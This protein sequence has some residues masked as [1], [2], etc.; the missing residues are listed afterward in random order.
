MGAGRVACGADGGGMSAMCCEFC[1]RL[2]DTDFDPDSLYVRDHDGECVCRSCRN[3]RDLRTEFDGDNRQPPANLDAM[4][5]A[6]IAAD[7]RHGCPDC[8]WDVDGCSPCEA[9][10]DV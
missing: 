9:H 7:P 2:V 1:R 4:I 3:D 8:D 5:A 6:E 10:A